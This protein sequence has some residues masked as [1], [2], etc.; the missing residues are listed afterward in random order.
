M[1]G[2]QN[3]FECACGLVEHTMRFTL[4]DTSYGFG[5]YATICLNHDA[6]LWKRLWIT[7]KYLVGHRSIYGHFGTW[8][9]H[10]EDTQRLLDMCEEH[11]AR[12]DHRHA[13]PQ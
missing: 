10:R 9:L 2:E 7:A 12:E 13:D 6:P 8:I 11:L 4:N 1:R 5:V 3:Y